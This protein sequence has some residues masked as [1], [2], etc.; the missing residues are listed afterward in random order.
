MQDLIL[1]ENEVVEPLGDGKYIIQPK[2]GYRF[3]SDSVALSKF[4]SRY[5]KNTDRVFDICSGCGIIGILIALGT[6]A[7]VSGAEIDGRLCDMSNRSAKLN[8]L[9]AVS[10]INADIRGGDAVKTFGVGSF[11]AVV[12]N[13][14][15][16]KTGSKKSSVASSANSEI[17]VTLDDV[18]STARS[19]L[20]PCGA[21]YLV[22]ITER[23]DEVLYK[24][25]EKKLT[26]KKL[27]VNA[28]SKTFMLRCVLLGRSGMTVSTEKF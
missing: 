8:E 7:A 28:N 4:A 10:F 1:N 12:C 5:I 13:P 17:T 26:P 20:K 11:D 2:I 6:G 3:G 14:P 23:L 19:L 18:L 15:Y 25:R 16:Y 9:D 22:H 21:L 27:T 24:C